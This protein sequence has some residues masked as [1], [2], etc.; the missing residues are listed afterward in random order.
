M[1]LSKDD[2]KAMLKD[3]NFFD[4]GWNKS[5]EG[6]DN[7]FVLQKNEQVV[8]DRN[9]GLMWQ[10]SGSENYMSFEEAKT[11]IE[12]LN[13]ADYSDWR[14]PTLEEAMSLMES[15]KNSDGLYIDLKFDKTQKYIWTSDPIKGEYRVWVVY[16]H[17][18]YCD[19]R[20][21]G[22][23]LYYY[24]YVRAVRSVKSSP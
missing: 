20:T 23:G 12:K 8:Y 4:Q 1:G 7:D 11:W 2:V 19:Y 13:F 15:E 5:G 6:F 22:I 16:F 21:F 3:K 14:L 24:G 18:G 10:Q 9:S 17:G